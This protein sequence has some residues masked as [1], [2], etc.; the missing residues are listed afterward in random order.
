MCRV[1]GEATRPAI[2]ADADSGAAVGD[3]DGR[4]S[5]FGDTPRGSS[6]V[7]SFP[8]RLM[9]GIADES[10]FLKLIWVLGTWKTEI[11]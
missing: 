6:I 2:V 7:S 8:S 11:S 3:F 4:L 9:E 10:V 1:G 5:K